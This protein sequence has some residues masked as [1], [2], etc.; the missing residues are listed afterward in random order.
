[1]EWECNNNNKTMLC[2]EKRCGAQKGDL[3]MLAEWE[4]SS[5]SPL[6]PLSLIVYTHTQ[7]SHKTEKQMPYD[8]PYIWNLKQQKT[9]LK[10]KRIDWL[11]PE[12][13]GE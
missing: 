9:S 6:S 12:D 1:M 4:R 13:G 2:K 5:F 10:I 8:L 3:K 11:L 7:F